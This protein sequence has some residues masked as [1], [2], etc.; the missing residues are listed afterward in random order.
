[1]EFTLRNAN[2]ERMP[3]D[4]RMLFQGDGVMVVMRRDGVHYSNDIKDKLS[5]PRGTGQVHFL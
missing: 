1:M 2:I 3:R 5:S 4:I